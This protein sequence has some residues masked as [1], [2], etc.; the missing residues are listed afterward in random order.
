MSF[1]LTRQCTQSVGDLTVVNSCM[2]VS[3]MGVCVDDLWFCSQDLTAIG[4][5]KPGH[6]KK[7]LSEI[8]KLSVTEWTLDQKPVS[9]TSDYQTRYTV[10]RPKALDS[11]RSFSALP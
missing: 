9:A 3:V 8:N 7:M 2:C 6:R 11:I 1:L 4:V 5:T 10:F